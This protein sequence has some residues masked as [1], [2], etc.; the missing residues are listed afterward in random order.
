MW[1]RGVPAIVC[2]L[3]GGLWILQGVGVAKGSFM[4]GHAGWA[5]FGGI[6][7]V[8]GALLLVAA[9]RARQPSDLDE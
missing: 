5:V 7:F 1:S 4:T 3:V 6:L 2:L 8:A 9:L